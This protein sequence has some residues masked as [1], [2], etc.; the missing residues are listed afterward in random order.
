MDYTLILGIL[1][2]TSAMLMLIIIGVLIVDKI[3]TVKYNTTKNID[4]KKGVNID[5]KKYKNNANAEE[6]TIEEDADDVEEDIAEEDEKDIADDVDEEDIEDETEEEEEGDVTEEIPSVSV[7]KQWKLIFENLETWEKKSIIFYDAI[8]IGRKRGNDQFEKYYIVKDDPRVSKLHCAIISRDGQLY[9][10]DMD[11]RNGTYLN[12]EKL[13]RPVM[14]Q[15]EDVIG[16][17]ET[18]IEIMRVMREK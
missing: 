12:G 9:L 13:D 7:K 2:A 4:D 16:L 15:K 17:G 6:N 18:R 3:K 5:V 1:I 11:S 10:E 8:G 14:I